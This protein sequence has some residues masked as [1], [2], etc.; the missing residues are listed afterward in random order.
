MSPLL[1]FLVI[2]GVPRL[3]TLSLIDARGSF[4]GWPGLLTAL[5][6]LPNLRCFKLRSCVH[7]DKDVGKLYVYSTVVLFVLSRWQHFWLCI[8]S[9]DTSAR[10]NSETV[11]AIGLL[12]VKN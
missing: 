6:Y 11:K 3:E 7:S 5:P 2:T 1:L 4:S 9:C 8:S 10:T 12:A